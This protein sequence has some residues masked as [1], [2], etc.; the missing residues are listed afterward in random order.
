MKIEH[1]GC[2]YCI[3]SWIY[4]GYCEQYVVLNPP[5]IQ[6]D[7]KAPINFSNTEANI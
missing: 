5:S 7:R 6:I 2:K 1:F 3:W 4:Q